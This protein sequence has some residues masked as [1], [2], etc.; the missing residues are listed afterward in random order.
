MQNQ[1]GFTL[2]E[3][4]VT[5]AVAA[6]IISIAIP[7]FSNMLA[8]HRLSAAASSLKLDLQEARSEAIK[9]NKNVY[10]SFGVNGQKCASGLDWC[11]GVSSSGP[12]DPEVGDDEVCKINGAPKVV[13]SSSWSGISM[14]I[15]KIPCNDNLCSIYFD[16]RR[17]LASGCGVIKLRSD[18]GT[19]YVKISRI[20]H[21]TLTKLLD[22]CS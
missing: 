11:Y 20:G 22:E 18:V 10:V 15:K 3:L 19:L 8:R 9:L 16:P 21:V 12:C 7:S 14:S 6:V 1:R 13:T 2:L 5:L 17:G 4:I